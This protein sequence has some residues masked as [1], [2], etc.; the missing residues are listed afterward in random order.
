MFNSQSQ[1]STVILSWKVIITKEGGLDTQ[2][3]QLCYQ[4]IVFILSGA[5]VGVQTT[6]GKSNCQTQ[7]WHAVP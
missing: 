4:D 7:A 2:V 1:L 3:I 5:R 6:R